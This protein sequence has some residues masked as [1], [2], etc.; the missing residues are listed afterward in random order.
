M[1]ICPA[2][3]KAAQLPFSP[4]EITDV[5]NLFMNLDNI[6][7]TT[8]AEVNGIPIMYEKDKWVQVSMDVLPLI[9]IKY[10][11]LLIPVPMWGDVNFRGCFMFV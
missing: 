10:G 8:T 5:Y 4:A 1:G 2:V 11:S 6:F 9:P 3:S 7:L